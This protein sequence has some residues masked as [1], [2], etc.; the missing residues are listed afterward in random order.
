MSKEFSSLQ[1]QEFELPKE[2][3]KRHRINIDRLKSIIRSFKNLEVCVIGDLIIDEYIDCNTLGISQEE[4]TVVVSPSEKRKFV[5]G[6]GIVAAHA[7]GLGASVNYISIAGK[8]EE[9]KF[10]KK[11]CLHMA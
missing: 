2:Y 4:P 11:N 10:A 5:G 8:D 6:S 3:M 1:I 7:A 9:M